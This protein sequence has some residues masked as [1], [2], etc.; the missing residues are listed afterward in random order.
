MINLKHTDRKISKINSAYN[1]SNYVEN[2]NFIA[3]KNSLEIQRKKK[4]N[5]NEQK[6]NKFIMDETAIVETAIV[7]PKIISQE[8]KNELKHEN[9]L[10]DLKI[11][12]NK[13]N[14][15]DADIYIAQGKLISINKIFNQLKTQ[16][17]IDIEDKRF[18]KLKYLYYEFQVFM[19]NFSEE[20]VILKDLNYFIQ[21]AEMTGGNEFY[22]KKTI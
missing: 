16:K 10:N 9:D 13:F 2:I 1:L 15:T 17:T 6:T 4:H 21:I 5:L 3:L 12:F 11:D 7:E 19:S 22:E 18:K 14:M 20:K 8:N